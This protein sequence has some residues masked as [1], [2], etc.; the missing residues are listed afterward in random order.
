MFALLWIV[1]LGDS[2]EPA[3]Q[4]PSAANLLDSVGPSALV[5]PY[6][7]PTQRPVPEPTY[8]TGRALRDYDCGDFSTHAEADDRRESIAAHRHDCRESVVVKSARLP[9]RPP[10]HLIMRVSSRTPIR[11]IQVLYPVWGLADCFGFETSA[12]PAGRQG[13]RSVGLP[14]RSERRDVETLT[15]PMRA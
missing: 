10:S 7:G 1:S 14:R 2:S 3:R 4:E 9:S 5:E 11:T 15:T 6:Q 13:P 12:R 8:S